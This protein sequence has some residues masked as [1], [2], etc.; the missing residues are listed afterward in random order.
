MVNAAGKGGEQRGKVKR[1]GHN[2]LA[3]AVRR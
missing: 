1:L 2:L 3:L